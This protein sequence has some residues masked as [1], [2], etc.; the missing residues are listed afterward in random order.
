MENKDEESSQFDKE[1][2]ELDKAIFNNI[3]AINTSL[4]GGALYEQDS[5]ELVNLGR[6]LSCLTD[7]RRNMY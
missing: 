2:K 7:L 4:S 1:K 3:L 6:V 5:E